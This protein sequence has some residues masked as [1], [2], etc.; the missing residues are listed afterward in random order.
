[1]GLV[2]VVF[3]LP[4]HKSATTKLA[5]IQ[6]YHIQL[7]FMFVGFKIT[8]SLRIFFK[9]LLDM[10]SVPLMT[11]PIRDNEEETIN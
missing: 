11:D 1:M 5:H 7:W 6:L 10:S 8:H 2:V 3:L 9:N 4:E